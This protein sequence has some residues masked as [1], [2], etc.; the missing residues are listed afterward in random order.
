MG[1]FPLKLL[2]TLELEFASGP[3]GDG[4][5]TAWVMLPGLE[6]GTGPEA[7]ASGA[8]SL[9]LLTEAFAAVVWPSSDGE[10]ETE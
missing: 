10:R 6:A 2:L 9:L 1:V 5:V 4:S 7:G 3:L 8:V